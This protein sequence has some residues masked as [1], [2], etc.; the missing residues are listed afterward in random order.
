MPVRSYEK[1]I[2]PILYGM[3]LNTQRL[4]SAQGTVFTDG[5]FVYSVGT[6]K[7]LSTS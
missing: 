6:R 4:F 1:I 2:T 7:A 5:N 3:Y